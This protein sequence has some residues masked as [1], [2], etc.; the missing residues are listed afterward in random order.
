MTESIIVA[1]ITGLFA[2]AANVITTNAAKRRDDVDR[3]K[4]QQHIDDEL[5][6]IKQKLDIH[7]GYAEKFADIT[8]DIATIK[9]EIANIKI[10]NKE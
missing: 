2:V 1:V 5:A 3:A 10:N 7:N 9:T 8:V 6:V 4:R